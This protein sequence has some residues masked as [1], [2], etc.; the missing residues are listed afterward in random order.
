MED[1]S[2]K[3]EFG[4]KGSKLAR[5]FTSWTFFIGRWFILPSLGFWGI[6]IDSLDANESKVSLP[7]SFWNK[8][9]FQSI[10]FAALAGAGELSTGTYLQCFLAEHQPYSMLVTNTQMSFSKKATERVHFVCSDRKIIQD[11]IQSCLESKEPQKFTLESRGHSGG[12][13]ICKIQIEWSIKLK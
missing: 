13:E 10:Y 1:L 7:Y 2:N 4:P 12:Q 8:N 6:R 9:P 3:T 11:A 5:K